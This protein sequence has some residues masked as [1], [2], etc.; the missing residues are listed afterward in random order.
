MKKRVKQKKVELQKISIS[1]ALK[2]IQEKQADLF[3]DGTKK[4]S[5]ELDKM[6]LSIDED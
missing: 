4:F 3:S 1:E 2:V 6:I 5:H